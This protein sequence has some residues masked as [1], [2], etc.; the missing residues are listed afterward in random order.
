MNNNNLS[1]GKIMENIVPVNG[2]WKQAGPD[3]LISNKR[4]FIPKL[5]IRDREG[6]FISIK[7]KLTKRIL[8]S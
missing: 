3:I 2:A 5:V 7:E 1:E 6:Y 8:E 4:G